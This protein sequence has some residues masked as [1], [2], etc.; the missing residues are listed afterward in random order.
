MAYTA[1]NYTCITVTVNIPY[2]V[3]ISSKLSVTCFIS[4]SVKYFEILVIL[5]IVIFSHIDKRNGLMF[6]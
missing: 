4:L 2:V 1:F 5:V 3:V 6:N